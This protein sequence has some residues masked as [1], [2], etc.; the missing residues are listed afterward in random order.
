MI[1]AI[2]LAAGESRRMGQQKVLL[3]FRGH[4]V[5]EHIVQQA[6]D[7]A[8]DEI[9]AVVGHEREA[10]ETC[11]QP[12]RVKV[13]VNSCY[14][15]GMLSSVRAG[16][17]A[18]QENAAAVMVLLGDQPHVRADVLRALIQRFKQSDKSIVIPSYRGRAGHPALVSLVHRN[19]I[20]QRYAEEGLR[21]L[22]TAHPDDIEWVLVEDAGIVEDMDTPEDYER[23]L[24]L[25]EESGA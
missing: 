11:L 19:E 16:L 23:V 4:T 20:M 22:Y 9:V 15:N 12:Y 3:P 8:V 13:V 5:I 25:D 2:V 10:V 14:Q 18:L 17:D 6:A 1:S 21:G 24:Q 7:A